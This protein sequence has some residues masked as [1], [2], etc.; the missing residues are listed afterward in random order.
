MEFGV[1]KCAKLIIKSRKIQITE[2]KELLNQERIRTLVGKE[3]YNYLRI[4][5]A[6][7]IKQAYMKEK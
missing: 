5:E 2:G 1:K 6:D 4:L 7:T 3:D